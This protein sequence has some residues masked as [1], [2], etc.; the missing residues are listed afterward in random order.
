MKPRRGGSR[1]TTRSSVWVTGSRLPVRMNH[2][3]PDQ[4]QL[5][6]SR[7]MRRIGLGGRVLGD[8]VDVEVAVVLPAHVVGRA[9]RRRIERNTRELGVLERLGVVAR[10]RLH[11]GDGDDLHQVVDD[12][13]AQR[14]D[15]VVEVAAVLD[16]EAL[17]HRDLHAG[18]V[19]AVPDRLDHRVAEA[20]V[21]ELVGAHLA[22]EV[23][24]PV[25]LGLVDVLVDFRGQRARGGEVVAERLLHDH[26]PGLGQAGVGELLDHRP[27]QE[28]RDLQVE[29][30]AAARRR[31]PSPGARRWRRR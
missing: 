10:G 2:G 16:A 5:S 3:T 27:E 30:R 20:Q 18:D 8:A 28:R 4:R 29:D 1:K 25:Q 24:D 19:V 26:A 21:Q 9:R 11:R 23:V 12:D 15:G 17:G 6:I 14:A 22:E 7:R 31:R 13:V